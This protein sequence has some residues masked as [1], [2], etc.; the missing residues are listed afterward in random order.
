MMKSLNEWNG[1]ELHWVHPHLLRSEYEL[2]AGDEVLARIYVKGAFG[3]RVS[4]ETADSHWMID[5]KG[6][7]QT[8]RVLFPDTG[9]ELATI[10]HEGSDWATLVFPDGREYRWQRSSFWHDDW[11]WRNLEGTPLLHVKGGAH[12]QLEPAAQGLSELVLLI[13]L[14]WYLHK[15]QEKEAATIAASVPAVMS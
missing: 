9:A 7:H 6:L 8:M 3:T 12:I 13:T 15:Q 5:R 1:Q 4:V 14:G 2:R 10:R 11:T